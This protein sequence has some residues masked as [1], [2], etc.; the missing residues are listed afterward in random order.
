M[1]ESTVTKTFER[2][3]EHS[4]INQGAVNQV[5]LS[6]SETLP[7]G[8]P[9]VRASGDRSHCDQEHKVRDPLNTFSR[10]VSIRFFRCH[11]RAEWE[12]AEVWGLNYRL[13]INDKSIDRQTRHSNLRESY[14]T[15]NSFEDHELNIHSP[16]CYIQ[17]RASSSI[18]VS[19]YTTQ[20]ER[21]DEGRLRHVD[22]TR[23]CRWRN[24][25]IVFLH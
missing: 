18:R 11:R 20:I 15:P 3:I 21:Y 7:D 17:R 12:I 10:L 9:K 23:Y 13:K 5:R 8:R 4:E 16:S 19:L 6:S 2:R 1:S 25:R 24:C 14:R 22:F